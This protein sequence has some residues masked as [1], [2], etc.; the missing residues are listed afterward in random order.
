MFNTWRAIATEINTII[1][2]ISISLADTG[3][4]AIVPSWVD[5]IGGTVIVFECTFSLEDAIRSQTVQ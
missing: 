3:E 5:E 4:G 1:P 2:D